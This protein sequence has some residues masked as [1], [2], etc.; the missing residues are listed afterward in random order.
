MDPP[1]PTQAIVGSSSLVEQIF[2]GSLEF[3][4]HSPAQRRDFGS[5]HDGLDLA[6][7]SFRFHVNTIGTVRLPDPIC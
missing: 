6:F 7:G 1:A 4:P 5:L 3:T 2:F